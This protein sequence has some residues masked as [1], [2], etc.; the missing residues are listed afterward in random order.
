MIAQH[1]IPRLF[2]VEYEYMTCL[3][4]AEL[5][6]TRTLI[7]EM[8]SGSLDGHGDVEPGSTPP[9]RKRRN[10]HMTNAIEAHDLQKTFGGKVRA[11]DGV[12]FAVEEGTIFGLLGPNGAGK[13]TAVRILTT[14]LAPDAGT[15]RVL[16]YDVVAQAEQVRTLIGLAGQYAAV[17]EN[18]TGRENLV[19]VGRLN[20]MARPAVGRGPSSCSSSS[21][22][23][24][25]A[26]GPSRPTPAA[27]A[28]ASTW[29]PPWWPGPR[30]SSSTSPPP[31]ST[32]RAEST[33]G[34]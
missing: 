29:P 11:L 15:G 9:R 14:I 28:G 5:E 26:T 30:C 27:C 12:S 34:P 16:G 32:P 8:T 6:W 20:H 31:G 24:T 23:P 3:L 10:A 1:G 13:T 33:C 25:P 21:A 4:E 18:L 19:M 17:D 2:E 22:S 7:G